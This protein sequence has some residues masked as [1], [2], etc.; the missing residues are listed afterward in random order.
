MKDFFVRFVKFVPISQNF[1]GI[2]M[3]KNNESCMWD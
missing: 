1:Q 3:L 2:S